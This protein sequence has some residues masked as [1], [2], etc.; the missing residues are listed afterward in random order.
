[1]AL[2]KEELKFM[3][4]LTT[5]KFKR[6]LREARGSFN[7]FAGGFKKL[8]ES[9][10]LLGK[11]TKLL[12]NKVAVLGATT[13]AIYKFTQAML[14]GA[15]DAVELEKALT[16]INTLFDGP[17]GLTEST[18]KFITEQAKIYGK[19][20]Q[21]NAKAY[22]DIV[23]AGFTDQAEANKILEAANKAAVA[24]LSDV[25]TAVK[26]ISGVMNA[27]GKENVT[28]AEASDLLFATVKKG[29]I[30]FPQLANNIGK[31]APMAANLGV[32]LQEL[33]ASLA[34]ITSRAV[35]VQQANTAMIGILASILQKKSKEATELLDKYGI[36]WDSATLATK[37]FIPMVKDLVNAMG[38][39][40]AELQRVIPEREA[41]N[42]L[43]ILGARN[44]KELIE[45]EKAMY[46]AAGSTTSAFEK[47]S[48]IMA[49]RLKV[50]TEELADAKRKA[51][52]GVS[53][54]I[55][56]YKQ[57]QK[58]IYNSVAGIN[59]A[60]RA[61]IEW[62]KSIQGLGVAIKVVI[63]ALGL[64][65]AG[66]AS[67][68]WKA[69]K[70]LK[71]VLLGAGSLAT[72]IP[73]AAGLIPS[74]KKSG[75]ATKAGVATP[76]QP[77]RKIIKPSGGGGGG[78]ASALAGTSEEG[79]ATDPAKRD[80]TDS[81]GYYDR[82]G[83][84]H[85]KYD[86]GFYH[87]K[88]LRQREG[89]GGTYRMPS[90]KEVSFKSP[91]EERQSKKEFHAKVREEERQ[92]WLK[93]QEDAAKKQEEAAKKQ[94]EAAKKQE[95]AAKKQGENLETLTESVPKFNED[96]TFFEGGYH[97]SIKRENYLDFIKELKQ[98]TDQS[99]V[100][101]IE[102]MQVN[103]TELKQVLEKNENFFSTLN[104]GISDSIKEQT[105]E[106]VKS[107]KDNS[108]KNST[109]LKAVITILGKP[110]GD[111]TALADRVS[112]FLEPDD[113]DEKA[114]EEGSGSQKPIYYYTDA[115]G[116]PGATDIIPGSPQW[117]RLTGI[118]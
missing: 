96:P 51:A 101:L 54:L 3:L 21:D 100:N 75:T 83:K 20:A 115:Q 108:H 116:R 84:F 29:I 71:A 91:Y 5:A 111:H 7:K 46:S 14:E 19:T 68:L 26:G 23:S 40:K 74:T 92:A 73:A 89:F 12:T 104:S 24:G 38:D 98:I 105:K 33:Q 78:G 39:N 52:H 22:Y 103:F 11:T 42:G 43:L 79:E 72:G 107:L 76:K 18:K 17:G 81:E 37:G 13:V 99:T 56:K 112:D 70:K 102:K 69:G 10:T 9:N 61:T 58:L 94:E 93:T 85:S 57:F 60:T 2:K 59:S 114:L 41:L 90:G 62:T 118:K 35:S 86:L 106:L 32:S 47:Q 64:T 28:A 27:Y 77:M 109:L 50:A 4:S 82:E 63:A 87:Y 25:A 36:A 6:K 117:Q 53:E 55:I 44:T 31:V 45:A 110:E 15:R 97:A 113:L 66:K 48:K 67:G 49:Q 1:M 8:R 80:V 88:R 30:T 16:N 95:E 65:G 34:H